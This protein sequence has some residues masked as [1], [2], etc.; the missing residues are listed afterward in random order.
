MLTIQT[1]FKEQLV[2]DK[3][4]FL[5]CFEAFIVDEA[6]EMK[7]SSMLILAALKNFVKKSGGRHKIIVTSATLNSSLFEEYFSDLKLSIIECITPTY[8]VEV[9]YTNFPDLEMSI[10]ENTA[11]HLKIIFEV[12]TGLT[13]AYQA[14]LSEE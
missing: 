4:D 9:H 11:S 13:L 2:E 8:E 14:K 5:N 7:K 1:Q 12:G 6:H 3:L 10:I